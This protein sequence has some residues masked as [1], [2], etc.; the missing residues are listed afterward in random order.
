M[1]QKYKDIIFHAIPSLVAISLV[2]IVNV[3]VYLHGPVS[4]GVAMLVIWLTL[5]MI[6]GF[7]FGYISDRYYRKK[8]L[9]VSQALGVLA[10]LFLYIFGYEIWVL[11]LIALTFNPMPVARAAFLDNYP[12]HST[13]RL[14]AITFL[15]QYLPWAFYNYIGQF[16]YQKVI[17]WTLVVLA[18]NTILTVFWFKDTYDKQKKSESGFEIAKSNRPVIYTLIAFTLS[19]LTFYLLWV[20][21]EYDPQNSFWLS[22]MTYATLIGILIAMLYTRL[23]HISTITLFYG[24]G[25]G[26]TFIS[27]LRCLAS[28]PACN[29]TF[30]SAM[31]HYSVIG[32]IYLPFATIAVINMLG[33]RH[34]ALGSASI[35]FGDT[36]ASFVAPL[37]NIL[38]NESILNISMIITILYILATFAQRRAENLLPGSLRKSL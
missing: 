32:G 36:I 38:V 24:I 29:D 22:I 2:E 16:H 8:M 35:E 21:L 19:E 30:I 5:Q 20:Y 37:I 1:F 15:A 23:P 13:L 25:A 11:V 6:P 26:I 31:S 10:G 3:Q 17:L 14:V 27:F 9:V 34:K 7:L 28:H 18:L 4:K 12:Q 33:P